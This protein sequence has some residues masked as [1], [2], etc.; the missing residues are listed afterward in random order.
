MRV[1]WTLTELVVVVVVLGLLMGTT[2]PRLAALRDRAAVRAAAA[3][4]RSALAAA[5]DEA[6]NRAAPAVLALDA[7]ERRVIVLAGSGT[8][9][10]TVLVQPLAPELGVSLERTGDSVRFAPSGIG[11]GVSNTTIVLRRGDAAD[12]LR[13]SRLGRVR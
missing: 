5:R 4:V 8:S 12:T 10:D 1:G 3:V 2:A 7:A 13:V 11:Y 9:R 6:R